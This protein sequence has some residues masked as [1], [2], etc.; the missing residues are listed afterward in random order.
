MDTSPLETAVSK[1]STACGDIS[2]MEAVCIFGIINLCR[3]VRFLVLTASTR[4]MTAFWD[5]VPCSLV[6]ADRRFRGAYCLMI[7]RWS[8]P[9]ALYPRRPSPSPTGLSQ[10]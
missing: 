5:I 2:G 9:T 3:P 1:K 8:A 10:F 4:K 7:E 6:G